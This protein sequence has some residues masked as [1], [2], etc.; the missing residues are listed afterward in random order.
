MTALLTGLGLSAAA[1]FNAW[2][3]LIVFHAL[4]RLLPQ[5]LPGFAAPLLGSQ[6]VF[7]F[8][9]VLFLAEFVIDKIPLLDRFWDLAHTLLRPVVGA[10]LAIAA[11]PATSLLQQIGIGFGGAVAAAAAHLVKSTT[12]LETTAA[13]H[14]WTQF[15]LSLTEDAVAVAIA[16]LVFFVPWMTALFLVALLVLLATHF[17]RVRSALAVLFFRIQHPRRRQKP[18]DA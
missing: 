8:A 1:G 7:S 2:A 12:R 17:D 5:E 6:T 18:S 4:Y 10:L 9:L 14:G 11:V 15:A 16:A 13:T 3:V